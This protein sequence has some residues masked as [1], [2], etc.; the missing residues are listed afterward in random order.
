MT[1][2]WTEWIKSIFTSCIG[3][4]VSCFTYDGIPHPRQQNICC[5]KECGEYCGSPK[6]Y[7]GP[8]GEN[9]CCGSKIKSLCGM[10]PCRLGNS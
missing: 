10:A 6:C 7:E 1:D 4:L 3:S 9:A 2:T 5:S 8:G